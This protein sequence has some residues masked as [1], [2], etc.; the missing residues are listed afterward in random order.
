MSPMK[1]ARRRNRQALRCG[2]A[3]ALCRLR[4]RKLLRMG[5]RLVCVL[6]S[7]HCVAA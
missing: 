5:V 7:W 3:C 4:A 1:A 6:E 2:V